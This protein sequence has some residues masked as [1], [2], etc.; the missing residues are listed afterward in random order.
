MVVA[1][2]RSASLF[3]TSLVIALLVLV[4][5]QTAYAQAGV[6]DLTGVVTD[7][8]GGTVSGAKVKLTNKATGFEREMTTGD[9]GVYRFSALTVAGTYVL[10][11]EHDGFRIARV[12]DIVVSVGATITVDVRL[13]VGEQAQTVTVE[14]GAELVNPSESQISELVDRRVWETLPLEVRNQNTF[15]NL[16]AGVVPGNAGDRGTDFTGTTRGAAVNGA[17]PGMGNFILEGYDNNDQGQGGR[18]SEGGGAITSISPEAIEEYRVITHSFSAEYGK[19]G[20]FVTDTVLKSGTDSLH[21]SLFEYNRVQALAANDFFSNAA[22]IKDSLVRNQFGGSIGGPILK[23]KWFFYGSYEGHRRRQSSPLPVVTGTT[24]QFIDFV[25]SGAFETFMETNPAGF[26]VVNTGATCPGA[27]AQSATLGPIAQK[28]L[29]TQPFPLAKSGLSSTAQG[30]YTSTNGVG[31]ANLTYP[32]P[33][34]GNVTLSDPTSFNQHRVSFKSD[35]K[36]SNKDSLS[37]T[38]LYTNEN[39][40]D[41]FG[42]GCATIGPSFS[43]PAVSV[44]LGL[45]Y[46]RNLTPNSINQFRASYLR[47]RS[48]FPDA[49]GSQG[50]PDIVTFTDPLGIGFGNTSALP[51]FFTDGQFQYKDDLSV[52]HGKH[53]VKLGGEYRR[54]RNA[55][56]FQSVKNGFFA[57]YGIEEILTDG[58]FGDEADQILNGG[59]GNFANGAFGEAQASINPLTGNFPEYYRGYRANEVALYSQ[60]DWKISPRLTLNLGLRWEY[61]GPPHNFRPGL[62][63][64]IFFGNPIT[65]IPV[66]TSN[67]FYPKNSPGA[68]EVFGEQAIQVNHNIWNK[69]TNNFGPR[70]GFAWDVLG[71]QK[72]VLRGGGGFYYDR[73]WNNL[74]ENIRFNPPFFAISTLGAQVGAPPVGPLATPGLYGVPFTSPQPFQRFAGK[75]APRHMDQN[76]VTPYTQQATLGM[77]WGFAKNFVLEV[78]GTYTGGRELTGIRDINTYDG[79]TACPFVSSLSQASAQCQAAAAAGV[80]PAAGFISTRRVNSSFAGDNFRTNAFGS[81]YYGLQVVV[82][83]RFANGL[84]FNSNYTWSHAIDTLSDAFN[85]GR[86]LIFRPT[87]NFNLPADKGNA[88]FDIRHRF[89]TSLSYDLPFLKQHRWIGGWSASG[90]V[91]VQ[92]GVPIGLFNGVTA[93]DLNRDG[94]TTDRPL[95]TGNPYLSGKSP[96]DGFLNPAAF[97]IPTCPSTVNFGLWCDSPT[98]RNTLIGPGFVNTDFGVAKSIRFAE[99][100]KFTFEANFFNV[101]NHT[102][103]GVPVGNVFGGGSQFGKSTSE[104]G[105]PRVTQLA[106]RLTF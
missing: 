69:D 38:F 58:F 57:P 52:V 40:V 85:G 7:Q 98:G 19:G 44:L 21:G 43:N 26:C 76:L 17:R 67:I 6:G 78:N 73:I 86:A 33:V 15:I 1:R 66:T 47:R 60:D 12:A 46:T 79:R 4:S 99:R 42:G 29:Q 23:D 102:N 59:A 18:G 74:F 55:S 8:T 25:K 9:G 87:D 80:I 5:Q 64:N 28:L 83:R 105:G 13:E 54:T 81:N 11:A 104:F 91:T 53:S 101:F 75:P 36:L 65:P 68:A 45:T 100:W 48:D 31:A 61:F 94:Y 41:T 39:T 63:S 77:Q 35:Y 51:Q 34:Y 14:A 50:I 27:F 62:D 84:Q 93:G 96:A 2:F 103:F 22:G 90:I 3:A 37:G 106:L 82:V 10:T 16:V 20:A 24:Q 71:N 92:K 95:I 97:S 32:V 89:V 30:F 70:L 88:D 72:L 49:P 56:S